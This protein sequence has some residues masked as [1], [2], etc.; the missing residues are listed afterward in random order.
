MITFSPIWL[1]TAYLNGTVTESSVTEIYRVN[2][3]SNRVTSYGKLGFQMSKDPVTGQELE[4]WR[5]VGGR[6]PLLTALE[7]LD[8]PSA[9]LLSPSYKMRIQNQLCL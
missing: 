3:G 6:L 9:L 7:F 2:L 8:P 5:R 4:G 1:R